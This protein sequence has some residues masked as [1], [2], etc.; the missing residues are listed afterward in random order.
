MNGKR[1][2]EPRRRPHHFRSAREAERRW[3]GMARPSRPPPP[4]RARRSHRHRGRTLTTRR[5][6]P[7]R[8]DSRSRRTDRRLRRSCADGAAVRRSGLGRLRPA[9]ASISGV[10]EPS[11]A[12]MGCVGLP[13]TYTNPR[14]ALPSSVASAKSERPRLAIA[15]L[16]STL[17]SQR[18]LSGVAGEGQ[19]RGAPTEK[20]VLPSPSQSTARAASAPV[21]RATSR[22]SVRSRRA[23]W[24]TST[25]T[26]RPMTATSDPR[27]AWSASAVEGPRYQRI[28]DR[29]PSEASESASTPVAE[30][31]VWAIGREPYGVQIRIL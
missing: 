3:L 27:T 18:R 9:D 20:S 1:K 30:R 26:D 10:T 14:N 5:R 16:A 19:T 25:S 29:T 12:D 24:A 2:T 13:S 8:G 6:S 22:R 21:A 7:E 31:C 17:L 11:R 28:N 15:R 23:D 4:P